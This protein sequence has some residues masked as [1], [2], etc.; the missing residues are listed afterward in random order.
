MAGRPLRPATDHRLG[1]P[2]PPQLANRPQA[3]PRVNAE[4]SFLESSH[5]RPNVRGIARRF[6][7]LSPAPGQLAHVLRTRPP[8]EPPE[9]DPVR[10]ACIRHAASV[11]P[12]PGSNSPPMP[13][14]R[15]SCVLV[16]TRYRCFR[17]SA[18]LLCCARLPTVPLTTEA[19]EIGKRRAL[20]LRHTTSDL[21]PSPGLVLVRCAS[22]S[23][24]SPA[25]GTQ[26]PVLARAVTHS[27]REPGH[28]DQRR[29]SPLSEPAEPTVPR[30]PLSSRSEKEFSIRPSCRPICTPR[31]SPRQTRIIPRPE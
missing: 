24:C 8:R 19:N 12:E 15:L 18:G 2:L 10:L 21:I 3:P 16:A 4:T 22:L 5:R 30:Q 6:R 7:R 14:K 27:H 23:T 9:R 25:V 11:D 31:R 29:G 28:P 1:K 17:T 13:P 26:A 20:R